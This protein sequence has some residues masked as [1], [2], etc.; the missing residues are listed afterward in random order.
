MEHSAEA[1]SVGV[2]QPETAVEPSSEET[3]HTTL[4]NGDM[5]PDRFQKAEDYKNEGNE[6]F[7]VAKYQDAYD[8][9]SKAI[10]FNL[11]GLKQ[12]TYL[13]NRAFASLKLEN[14]G[15]A[16]IDAKA[17]ID[18]DPTYIKAYYRRGCAY[19]A[20]NHL[21]D[22]IKDFKKVCKIVPKDKDARNKYETTL[23]IKKELDFAACIA[24]EETKIEID[25][26]DIMVEASYNG[27]VITKKE[28]VTPEW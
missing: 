5:D 3:A 11:G 15:I 26:E 21:S 12:C 27:P 8:A 18:I 4:D 25:P 2:S 22:A 24:V 9:Y 6:Y 10:E 14:Y 20:L 13:S 1:D 19:F 16:I 7:K 23:K 28:D 17:A